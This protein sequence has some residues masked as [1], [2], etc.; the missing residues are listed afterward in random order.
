MSTTRLSSSWVV[1]CPSAGDRSGVR[2]R[3]RSW[4][5][6]C[7]L[8]RRQSVPKTRDLPGESFELL[9]VNRRQGFEA[10]RARAGETHSDDPVIVRIPCSNDESRAFGAID[11]TDDAVVAQEEVVGHFADRRAPL[12]TVASDGE[13]ELVLGRGEAGGPRLL[14][15]PSLKAPQAGS[16]RQ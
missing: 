9:E 4:E 5:T 1:G 15:A 13:K 8:D 7:R 11:E 12:V 6:V 10:R 16:Q 14:L 3:S 2:G